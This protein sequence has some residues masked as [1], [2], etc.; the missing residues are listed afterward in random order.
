MCTNTSCPKQAQCKPQR[1]GEPTCLCGINEDY[2]STSKKCQESDYC[3][4]A[5]P[6]CSQ[7]C[8]KHFGS[9]SCSCE[10]GYIRSPSGDLCF[11]PG[12]NHLLLCDDLHV[13]PCGNFSDFLKKKKKLLKT[14][15]NCLRVLKVFYRKARIFFTRVTI[16]TIFMT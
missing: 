12:K 9:Y 14:S 2:N 10:E 5:K 8:Q 6:V 1:S 11:A 15:K 4:E 7:K 16:S 13:Y 3:S